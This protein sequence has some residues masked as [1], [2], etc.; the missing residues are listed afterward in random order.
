MTSAAAIESNHLP[1]G[2]LG[3]PEAVKAR[4][5]AQGLALGFDAVGFAGIDLGEEAKARLRAWLEAG[6]HGEMD[7]MARHGM[8]RLEPAELVPGTLS[9]ITVRMN[10]LAGDTEAA[11]GR[12]TR[13]GE[14]YVSVYAHGRDYHKVLRNRL[15]KLAEAVEGEVGPHGYRVFTDSAPVAEVLLAAQGGLGWRGKHTL[16]LSREAG[17]FFFLGEIYTSLALP[18]DA[19]AGDHCGACFACAQ[20]CPTGAI[21]GTQ[22]VDA[23]RC[24]SYLTI[25]LKGAIAED[26]R[27]LMGNRVY[28]CDDCQLFCPWNKFAQQAA[29]PDFRAVRNGLDA[30]SLVDL[31]GWTEAEFLQRMA[32]S[33]ILRIGYERWL[34]NLAVALGNGLRESDDED[35]RVRMRAA[36]ATRKDD[37]SLLLRE[38]VAWALAQENK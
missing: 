34:R 35:L 3:D 28:G 27:P 14:A 5:R 38:H 29:E 12:L 30:S 4:I 16:L 6:Y 22:T 33:A 18:P 15:Q 25:E 7:Y 21:I 32:G 19:P 36:L 26:L 17:S 8:T 37:V 24:I 9:V 11:R 10:Y 2:A 23:R 1:P 13:P 20:A 31:F